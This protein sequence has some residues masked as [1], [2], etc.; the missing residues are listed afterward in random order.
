MQS[1]HRV[2][3]NP[4]QQYRIGLCHI[5]KPVGGKYHKLAINQPDQPEIAIGLP[6]RR[7]HVSGKMKGEN[8]HIGI[9]CGVIRVCPGVGNQLGCAS[10]DEYQPIIDWIT[11]QRAPFFQRPPFAQRAQRIGNAGMRAVFGQGGTKRVNTPISRTK[12]GACHNAIGNGDP[13]AIRL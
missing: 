2:A 4:A 11:I 8:L 13:A 6:E 10:H 9:D 1:L 3:K 7:N 12:I 5:K